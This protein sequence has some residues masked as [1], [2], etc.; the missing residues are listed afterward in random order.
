M[1]QMVRYGHMLK[2]KLQRVRIRTRIGWYSEGSV[3]AGTIGSRCT[4]VESHV[5]VDSEDDPAL[6]AALIH[7]A[8]GGCYAEAALAQPLEVRATAALNGAELDL[9]SYPSKPPRRR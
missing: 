4:G 8:R 9:A 1:T 5:D 3:L 6:V 2:A 7:N